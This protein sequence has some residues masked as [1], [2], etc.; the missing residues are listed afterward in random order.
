[1]T[2]KPTLLPAL[3]QLSL[4]FLYLFLL[5]TLGIFAA[6]IT[7]DYARWVFGLW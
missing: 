5:I 6:K 4:G 2:K 1:M 7:Y 3:K